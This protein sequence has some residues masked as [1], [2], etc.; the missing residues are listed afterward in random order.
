VRVR[1]RN[2]GVTPP[3]ITPPAPLCAPAPSNGIASHRPGTR[4][5][6]RV[7]E[8][9]FPLTEFLDM[10]VDRRAT[11]ELVA[12]ETIRTRTDFVHGALIFAMVDTSMGAATMSMLDERQRCSTIERHLRFLCPV[13]SGRLS[14]DTTVVK[15]GRRRSHVE[16]KVHDAQGRWVAMATGSS[17]VIDASVAES[18]PRS[19]LTP[20]VAPPCLTT[21]TLPLAPRPSIACSRRSK[22]SQPIASMV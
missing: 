6:R 4:G 22:S 5:E 18:E 14:A 21:R 10:R 11:A 7:N 12:T 13:E 2:G 20:A 9:C 17:A 16:S 1:T 3:D 15:A 8:P 19:S